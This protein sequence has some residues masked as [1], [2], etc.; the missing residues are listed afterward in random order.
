[1]LG[2][3]ADDVIRRA[4]PVVVSLRSHLQ[5]RYLMAFRQHVQKQYRQVSH[6]PPEPE[7]AVAK[8]V[9]ALWR[10]LSEHHQQNRVRPTADECDCH[11]LFTVPALV[12]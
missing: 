6:N 7:Q 8:F 4:T 12:G 10:I 11:A 1:M 5:I 3:G 9:R 2:D